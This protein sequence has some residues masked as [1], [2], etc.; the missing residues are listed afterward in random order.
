[1]NALIAYFA[2]G[3]RRLSRADAISMFHGAI[4][5]PLHLNALK[6]SVSCF[7]SDHD[8]YPPQHLLGRAEFLDQIPKQLYQLVRALARHSPPQAS[9]FFPLLGDSSL[10]DVAKN[11]AHR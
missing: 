6:F 10:G 3:G 5:G 9:L 4:A 7:A 11:G 2:G 1:M 8:H